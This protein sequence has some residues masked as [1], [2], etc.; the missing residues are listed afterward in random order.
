MLL[1]AAVSLIWAIVMGLDNVLETPLTGP[2]T[3]ASLCIIFKEPSTITCLPTLKSLLKETSPS[4]I[5]LSSRL[6]S[7]VISAVPLITVLPVSAATENLISSLIS[8]TLNWPFDLVVPSIVAVPL[9]T[10]LPVSA[11]T[12]NFSLPSGPTFKLFSITAS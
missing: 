12:E 8:T 10:V 6:V 2:S 3:I 9:I 1:N 7:P 11:A 4:T 5:N